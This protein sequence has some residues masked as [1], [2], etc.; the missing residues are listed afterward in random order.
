MRATSKLLAV[1]T[2]LGG[3]YVERSCIAPRAPASSTTIVVMPPVTV[4][5]PPRTPLAP[6]AEPAARPRTLLNGCP[7]T[8]NVM[9]R[10]SPER[11]AR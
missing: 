11:R 5:A 6:V 8:G 10:P 9:R 1:V 3:A 2:F 7:A 4:E